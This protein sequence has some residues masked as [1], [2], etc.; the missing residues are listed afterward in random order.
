MNHQLETLDL[1]NIPHKKLLDSNTY[2]HFFVTNFM[3]WTSFRLTNTVYDS[4]YT[5][6]DIR[7]GEKEF[8]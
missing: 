4:K 1:L 5:F 6:L 2:K 3:L 7:L 8:S